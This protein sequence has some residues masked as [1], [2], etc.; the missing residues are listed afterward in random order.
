ML[1]IYIC[2]YY[3]RVRDFQPTLSFAQLAII[4][5]KNNFEMRSKMKMH[6]YI[7]ATTSFI[8]NIYTNT[9]IYLYLISLFSYPN[10]KNLQLQ[11][12]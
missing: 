12:I 1:L 3:Y 6:M 5:L 9:Y 10:N 7:K 2:M 4:F 11:N 8:Y